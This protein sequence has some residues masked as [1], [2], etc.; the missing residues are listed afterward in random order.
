MGNFT[1]EDIALAQKVQDTYGVPASVTL[2]QYAYESGYGTSN[3]AQTNNNYFGMR[4]GSNGWQSFN[5]KEDS[6]MA[7]G[8]LM[9]SSTYTSK[10]S[11]VT[12]ANDYVNAIA[13][14]YAP[15]SD[16]NNNY[17]GNVNKIINDN[18][19][20][21]YDN[22]NYS[23]W[24]SA[25]TGTTS[26]NVKWWGDIVIVVFA[27]LL[28]VGGVVFLAIAFTGGEPEKAIKKAVKRK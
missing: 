1:D 26:N 18:N 21:Q 2:A 8:K 4:N 7:Y 5:S 19:L 27:V 9:S 15:S 10:T 3:L 17:A 28:I 14:T 20:T 13:E 25:S 11:G 16:G 22:G 24:G 12:N 23:G 6:F